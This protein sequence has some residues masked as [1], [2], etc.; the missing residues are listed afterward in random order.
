MVINN[1]QIRYSY[2]HNRSENRKN[3]MTKICDKN[4][5]LNNTNQTEFVFHCLA[6]TKE[7]KKSEPMS[8]LH[9][10]CYNL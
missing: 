9:T 4:Y 3:S 1:K 7:N 6:Q 10:T 5:Y 2:S 8:T